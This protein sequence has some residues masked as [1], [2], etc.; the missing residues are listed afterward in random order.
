M[1]H[2]YAIVCICGMYGCVYHIV[3]L[4]HQPCNDSMG[5]WGLSVSWLYI[6]GPWGQKNLQQICKYNQIHTNTCK[7]IQIL[8]NTIF[9]SC[10]SIFWPISW[11]ADLPSS[12]FSSL[13]AWLLNFLRWRKR[14]RESPSS[15]NCQF[16]ACDYNSFD[17]LTQPLLLMLRSCLEPCQERGLGLQERMRAPTDREREVTAGATCTCCK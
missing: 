15:G 12:L 8:S 6:G 1:R 11:G 10:S 2:M 9:R 5:N 3:S 7:Y 16:P 4:V 14:E 17:S 13:S